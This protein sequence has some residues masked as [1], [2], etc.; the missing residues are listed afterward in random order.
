MKKPSGVP[1]G[2]SDL[3]CVACEFDK[4]GEQLYVFVVCLL[5]NRAFLHLLAGVI[6]ERDN[7]KK[8]VCFIHAVRCLW[9]LGRGLLYLRQNIPV[10]LPPG[11]SAEIGE[12]VLSLRTPVFRLPGKILYSDAQIIR[13]F[14]QC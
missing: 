10:F 4:V 13:H 9:L 6:D 2:F 11:A 7:F 12:K 1:E 8:D 5:G 14:R 3:L